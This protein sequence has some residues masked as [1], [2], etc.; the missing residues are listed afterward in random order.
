MVPGVSLHVKNGCVQATLIGIFPDWWALDWPLTKISID[1]QAVSWHQDRS[2]KSKE[3]KLCNSN[4][5]PRIGECWK[6][7]IDIR[8]LE[9][10][11]NCV[12][13]PGSINPVSVNLRVCTPE[14][15]PKFHVNCAPKVGIPSK[16]N[17]MKADIVHPIST[18]RPLLR[19]PKKPSNAEALRERIDTAPHAASSLINTW[20]R[21]GIPAIHTFRI[22][23]WIYD[24]LWIYEASSIIDF[25]SNGFVVQRR[26]THLEKKYIQQVGASF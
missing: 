1:H 13:I 9:R 4:A 25:T 6:V 16:W 18:L 11:I 17:R 2:F 14:K 5:L 8:I 19:L 21:A 26:T 24:H 22:I 23:T 12:I 10:V 15:C 20:W 3:Y 7:L